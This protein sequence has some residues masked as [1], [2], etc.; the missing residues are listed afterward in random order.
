MDLATLRARLGAS[1]GFGFASHDRLREVLG[2]EPGSVTPMAAVND[3]QGV[4]TVVLDA[5]IRDLPEV[6][7]HP[8]HNAATTRMSPGGLVRLLRHT[9]HEPVWLE[10][11]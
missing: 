4:V 2:V 1:S 11:A 6:H 3:V 7:C 10:L 8:L 9:G 5:A